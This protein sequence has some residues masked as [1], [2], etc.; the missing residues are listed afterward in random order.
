MALH[1][2]GCIRCG[3]DAVSEADWHGEYLR[4]IQ[5]G[6]YRDTSDDPARLAA[7]EALIPL[8]DQFGQRKAG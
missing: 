7:R 2:K 1:L 3:G 6:W 5:C 8:C 4:C